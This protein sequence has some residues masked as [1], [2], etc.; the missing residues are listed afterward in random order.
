M[1]DIASIIPGT[2][3]N[4]DDY[5]FEDQDKEAS[6][7]LYVHIE[8]AT[9]V[10]APEELRNELL[11]LDVGTK[12][13]GVAISNVALGL[14][15]PLTVLQH[16]SATSTAEDSLITFRHHVSILSDLIDTH[17]VAA[18]VVGW[19]LELDGKPGRQCQ[20]VEQYSNML[21]EQGK[22]MDEDMSLCTVNTLVW[23]ERWSS[24]AVR[25]SAVNRDAS[26]RKYKRSAV[27]KKV[28]DV[29]SL[30]IDDLAATY[31]LQNL[32][33]WLRTDDYE[34]DLAADGMSRFRP[35]VS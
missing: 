3:L 26:R 25:H 8:E 35:S 5:V 34:R 19:P 15:T 7:E 4:L 23:D 11:C 27:G 29:N 18:V 13:T 1:H 16:P 12:R 32:L 9:H 6:K 33:E 14:A 2:S 30:I 10:E 20:I 17:N 28:V 22:A 21:R 24:E 31:I